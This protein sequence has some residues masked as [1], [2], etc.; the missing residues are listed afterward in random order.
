[1]FLAV[2]PGQHDLGGS[3]EADHDAGAT[4]GVGDGVV[5]AAG[6]ALDACRRVGELCSR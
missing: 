5:E 2:E 3:V 4:D 6:L 1:V